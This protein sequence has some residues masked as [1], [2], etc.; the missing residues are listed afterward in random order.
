MKNVVWGLVVLL[1][2]LHQD[3]WLWEDATLIDGFLPVTLLFHGGLSI[4][5]AVTW[6]LATKFAWPADVV[7]S[8]SPGGSE[9]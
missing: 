1:V 4:A 6:F 3:N 5:A 9:A 8:S 7:E 2:I